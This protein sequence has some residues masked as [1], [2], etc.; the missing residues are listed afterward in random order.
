VL[1]HTLFNHS[2]TNV[3]SDR[4]VTD[5]PFQLNADGLWQ[6]PDCDW[7]YPRKSE[8]PPRRNCPKAKSR[9]LGDTIAKITKAVGIKPCGGCKKRQ[10]KL[11]EWFPYSP[12]QPRQDGQ[13][14]GD[15]E[16]RGDVAPVG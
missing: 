16:A 1:W 11:N 13:Q 10:K 14:A 2:R 9:G 12:E 5:C 3:R 15:G 4:S 7:V 8:K 6:C